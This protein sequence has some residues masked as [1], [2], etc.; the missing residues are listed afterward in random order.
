MFFFQS[1]QVPAKI[2]WLQDSNIAHNNISFSFSYLSENVAIKLVD[3]G[4]LWM[5]DWLTLESE[6]ATTALTCEWQTFCNAA[7]AGK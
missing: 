1:T 6:D 5:M 7:T 4:D 3:K 2:V